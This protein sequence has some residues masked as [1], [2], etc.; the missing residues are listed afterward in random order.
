MG[1]VHIFVATDGQQV[2]M[3]Q[4]EILES[5]APEGE[6]RIL[7]VEFQDAI[8]MTF[9]EANGARTKWLFLEFQ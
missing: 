3:S 2:T 8:A 7:N 6:V 1:H 4:N 9:D 5:S